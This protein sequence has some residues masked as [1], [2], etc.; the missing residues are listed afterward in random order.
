MPEKSFKRRNIR[1]GTVEA[2]SQ[3]LFLVLLFLFL[4]INACIPCNFITRFPYCLVVSQHCKCLHNI[5]LL[6]FLLLLLSFFLHKV[7]TQL[8]K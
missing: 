5:R 2:H 6:L 3:D 4:P 1:E 8:E 7:Q